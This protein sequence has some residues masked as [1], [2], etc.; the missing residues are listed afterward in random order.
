MQ[1]LANMLGVGVVLFVTLNRQGPVVRRPD[2]VD[3]CLF[4]SGG[5]AAAAGE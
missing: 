3:A 5:K 1:V 2:D 4:R